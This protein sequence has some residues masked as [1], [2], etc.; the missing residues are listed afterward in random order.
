M[1]LRGALRQ[2][3]LS[4]SV[5]DRDCRQSTFALIINN[6]ACFVMIKPLYLLVVCIRRLATK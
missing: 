2:V 6:V 1:E 4:C 5:D 3:D